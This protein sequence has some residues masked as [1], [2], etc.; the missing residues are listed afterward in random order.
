MGKLSIS[1]MVGCSRLD[2]LRNWEAAEV[3]RT[4]ID[5]L[6][7]EDRREIMTGSLMVATEPDALDFG[8]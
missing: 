4:R 8:Y 5:K 1:E 6:E 3:R 7:W 2:P